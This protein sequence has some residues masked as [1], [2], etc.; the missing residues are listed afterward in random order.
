MQNM[1]KLLPGKIMSLYKKLQKKDYS[2][3][4]NRLKKT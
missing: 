1:Q 3:Q 2:K 4:L